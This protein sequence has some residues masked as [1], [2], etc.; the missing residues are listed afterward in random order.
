M[1]DHKYGILALVA[2]DALVVQVS[3]VAFESKFSTSDWILNPYRSSLSLKTVEALICT[4]NW[5]LSDCMST[6]F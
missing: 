6:M 5:L 2:Q 1:C 3:I 4:K